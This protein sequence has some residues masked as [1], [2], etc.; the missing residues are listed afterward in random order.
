VVWCIGKTN[1]VLVARA[2]SEELMKMADYA[3]RQL[4][5]L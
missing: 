1:Y 5:L 2:R 4:E 3:R